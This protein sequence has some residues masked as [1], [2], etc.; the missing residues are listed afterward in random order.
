MRLNMDNIF[1]FVK[2]G[3][4]FFNE[5]L[6]KG[7]V[8]FS[9]SKKMNDIETKELIKGQGDKFDGKHI[10]ILKNIKIIDENGDEKV[11]NHKIR[12]IISYPNVEDM[13]MY[14]MSYI[15][16]KF[17]KDYKN[18]K[19]Y[20]VDC[21]YDFEKTI[22]EHFPKAD[23]ALVILDIRSFLKQIESNGYVNGKLLHEKIGY[24]SMN[25]EYLDLRLYKFMCGYPADEP[26]DMKRPLSFAFPDR[27]KI[28]FCKDVY[29]EG[30]EEY[31][32]LLPE[33]RISEPKTIKI[34]KI[35]N[36][37]L[38]SLED[39]FAGFKVIEGELFVDKS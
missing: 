29:F 27:H 3:E 30:E 31:R 8:Y 12:I 10:M 13:P 39:F 9:H 15:S 16:K 1:C 24:Y 21:G 28:L 6:Q 25:N 32:L 19:N 37:Y 18:K 4:K 11:F 33:R 22:R 23:S 36:S 38:L 20:K 17:C 5:K 14:C 26:L 34:D 7:E 35:E 2:F